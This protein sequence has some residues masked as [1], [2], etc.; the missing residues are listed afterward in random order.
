M[1]LKSNIYLRNRDFHKFTDIMN[2]KVIFIGG[3]RANT[4]SIFY[5]LVIFKDVENK[6]FEEHLEM[7]HQ[8]IRFIYC[9]THLV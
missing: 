3:Q 9:E 5:F 6:D 7:L 4:Q 8:H 2:H 1:N